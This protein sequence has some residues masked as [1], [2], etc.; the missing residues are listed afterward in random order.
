MSLFE[1]KKGIK[2]R[3]KAHTSNTYL[4]LRYVGG[5]EKSSCGS[6]QDRTA[7]FKKRKETNLL[8]NGNQSAVLQVMNVVIC[9]G[10]N[11]S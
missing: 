5:K 11:D 7:F 6:K 3:V 1:S 8:Q 10:L 4:I 9:I 2:K